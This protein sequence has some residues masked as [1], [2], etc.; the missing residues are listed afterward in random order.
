MLD[1]LVIVRTLPYQPEEIVRILA[2]RASVEGLQ[3]DE[4][5]LARMGE[6]STRL[7]A[8]R[9]Q[10]TEALQMRKDALQATGRRQHSTSKAEVKAAALSKAKAEAK[11]AA[12]AQATAEAKATAEARAAAEAK[13]LAVMTARSG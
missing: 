6:I 7:D 11:V 8:R 3:L 9:T 1:R 2:V 5:T 12:E 4:D 10:R 13:A